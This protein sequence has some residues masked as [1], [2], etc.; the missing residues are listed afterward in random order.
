[1]FSIPDLRA[2]IRRFLYHELNR[3]RPTALSGAS[4]PLEACPAFEDEPLTVY[5]SAASTFYAPSDPCGIGGMHREIIRANPAWR[6]RHPRFDCVFVNKANA[7]PGLLGME[8]ARVRMFFA[9]TYRRQRYS[10]AA[11]HWYGRTNDEV[12]EDTGMWIVKP[13]YLRGRTPLLSVIHLN[14]IVRAAHL[15]GSSVGETV[16]DDLQSHKALEHFSTFYVNKYV[17]HH[18]FELLHYAPPSQ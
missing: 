17:D 9:F 3:G 15:I 1:M 4:L 14:G 7:A 12:D 5:Y 6:T 10:C 13:S 11:V 16:S 18:A 2:H 8:V